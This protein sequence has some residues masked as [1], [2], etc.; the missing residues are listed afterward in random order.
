MPQVSSTNTIQVITAINFVRVLL[1]PTLQR[2]YPGCPLQLVP[3]ADTNG[4]K[5]PDY[6]YAKQ[7]QE[8]CLP[9]APF[10][11]LTAD[12]L[13]YF[14]AYT[15]SETILEL[16]TDCRP[17][18]GKFV[19]ITLT[20]HN[21]V[22]LNLREGVQQIEGGSE[23]SAAAVRWREMPTTSQTDVIDVVYA[24]PFRGQYELA[25]MRIPHT[26]AQ[27]YSMNFSIGGF[28]TRVI[29]AVQMPNMSSVDD[30][31]RACGYA[32][33]AAIKVLNSPPTQTVPGEAYPI[34]A[35]A[36]NIQGEPAAN[37][38]LCLRTFSLEGH[39]HFESMAAYLAEI[40]QMVIERALLNPQATRAN[41]TFKETH[42]FVTNSDGIG[43]LDF[44]WDSPSTKFRS[45]QFAWYLES[46]ELQSGKIYR[47]LTSIYVLGSTYRSKQTQFECL[48]RFGITMPSVART[49]AR[50]VDLQVAWSNTPPLLVLPY[51]RFPFFSPSIGAPI[52]GE[53]ASYYGATQRRIVPMDEGTDVR[54]RIYLR[55][56]NGGAVLDDVPGDRTD[57]F[58]SGIQVFAYLVSAPEG[59]P[60][61]K[62][63]GTWPTGR[64]PERC[65][66]AADKRRQD[67]WHDDDLILTALP[68][69]LG[70]VSTTDDMG[71]ARFQFRS[72]RTGLYRILF[73]VGSR[74]SAND[75]AT[76]M[77]IEVVRFRSSANCLDP[78]RFVP[79]LS[80]YIKNFDRCPY[81]QQDGSCPWFSDAFC[82]RGG[83]RNAVI[84]AQ[85]APA[86]CIP[87]GA[88][89]PGMFTVAVLS[90]AGEPLP[91][92]IAD[93]LGSDNRLVMSH[94]ST[95]G[96]TRSG[97][98]AS[99]WPVLDWAEV[100]THS[101]AFRV[102]GVK[103]EFSAFSE[104]SLPF[105]VT[106]SLAASFAVQPPPIIGIGEVPSSP[107]TVSITLVRRCTVLART[108][109]WR[110]PDLELTVSYFKAFNASSEPV[111]AGNETVAFIQ[112]T[113]TPATPYLELT[114]AVAASSIVRAG[115][116]AVA[117]F[118]N[119]SVIR[120]LQGVYMLSVRVRGSSVLLA[121]S[122][123]FSVQ[124]EASFLALLQD[125]PPVVNLELGIR[126]RVQARSAAG[127]AVAY[128]PVIASISPLDPARAADAGVRGMSV[129]NVSAYFESSTRS[130]LT[131]TAGVAYFAL[132]LLNAT[133]TDAPFV[134][135]FTSGTRAAPVSTRPFRIIASAY[136]VDVMTQ[137]RIWDAV[138]PDWVWPLLRS[139]QTA[140]GFG[141]FLKQAW[142][143]DAPAA[144]KVCPSP[145]P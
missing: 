109:H 18:S 50:F 20:A 33:I 91:N 130:A 129:N 120:G 111:A 23:L 71:V 31:V 114:G 141:T 55:L 3:T 76:L 83:V 17:V 116:S 46:A 34:R 97:G 107:I 2:T 9:M 49:P 6:D 112:G 63:T 62:G 78:A 82:E 41:Y 121:N 113:G 38:T 143:Q 66:A 74:A 4:D 103:N 73:A 64:P 24:E 45:G 52:L 133:R 27:N 117:V 65:V 115:S 51:S 126:L 89:F 19:S 87:L 118:S 86:T 122:T 25:S 123:A 39:Q 40:D 60:G 26:F 79:S 44:K 47:K 43:Q 28:S 140:V 42:C 10:V 137:P 75:F 35:L 7:V 68:A 136:A 139:K 90:D 16:S 101:V 69:S 135:T 12:M 105:T 132:F 54:H 98:N 53:R 100:G 125:V 32:P 131:D 108:D 67:C 21:R 57:L 142:V 29:V 8:I 106:D 102:R 11:T 80:P 85:P 81:R 110:P 138:Q 134:I 14:Q 99:A 48:A 96:P 22:A 61:T 84:L 88:R 92:F 104:P 15:C 144:M 37:T 93:M 36:I 94:D 59:F 145:C 58:P 1:P 5:S 77:E 30:A 72:V 124:T 128:A 13:P 127:S 119:F 70:M 56:Y 95:I